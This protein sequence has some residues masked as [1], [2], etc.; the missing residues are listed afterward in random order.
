MVDTCHVTGIVISPDGDPVPRA[1]VRFQR[2]P[3]E[4]F[5]EDDKTGIPRE[6]RAEADEDGNIAVDLIPG[7]YKVLII[8]RGFTQYPPFNVGVPD[9]ETAV[10]ADIQD[11]PPPPSLDDATRAVRDAREA[12]DEA[13][14]ARD[15]AV[16]S[17]QAAADAAQAA[18]GHA[19]AAAN[20]A[21]AAADSEQAAATSAGNAATSE[22]NAAASATAAGNSA[23]AAATSEQN[24]A[25]SASAAADSASAASTSASNADDAKQAAEA[26]AQVAT[27]KAGE[28]S[29]S[30]QDAADAA[31]AIP[32]M[33]RATE[34]V[35]VR[36]Q[37][38]IFFDTFQRPDDTTLGLSDS[39]HE[40]QGSIRLVNKAACGPSGVTGL[41]QSIVTLPEMDF[42]HSGGTLDFFLNI[43]AV[44]DLSVWLSPDADFENGLFLRLAELTRYFQI[45]YAKDGV[46]TIIASNSS[47]GLFV[48]AS[49]SALDLHFKVYRKTS[50][51][52]N[53]IKIVFHQ[54]YGTQFI[55]LSA[56]VTR[57]DDEAFFDYLLAQKTVGLA[58]GG[59]SLC[60]R[61]AVAQYGGEL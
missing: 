35:T 57:D 53:D 15:E 41:R 61:F 29:D 37:D 4:V 9:A 20:S 23:S 52:D 31:A 8:A 48:Q 11:V 19:T 1:T 59:N 51:G 49:R 16:V 50:Y 43:S 36:Q 32:A 6:V 3:H 12:R 56:S 14:S 40:W 24:A 18:E 5:V 47:G 44:R 30:A 46:E 54:G 38:L 45:G 17:A 7:E 34:S 21:Q 26:A 58:L 27:E 10:L 13:R 55:S 33:L 42:D 28:A 2:L 39:G 60:R 25:N 22:G